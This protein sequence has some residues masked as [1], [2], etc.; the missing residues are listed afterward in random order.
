M[1]GWVVE[2]E[3]KQLGSEE[4]GLSELYGVWDPDKEQA[5]ALVKARA[6]VLDERVTPLFEASDAILAGCK[7]PVGAARLVPENSLKGR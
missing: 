1:S 6:K 3:T 5:V 7:I 2:V 4:I